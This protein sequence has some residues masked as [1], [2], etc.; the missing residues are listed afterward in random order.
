MKQNL[1]AQEASIPGLAETI[2]D[3]ASSLLVGVAQSGALDDTEEKRKGRL[4][5]Q[6]ARRAARIGSAE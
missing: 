4:D 2:V 5:R 6:A 3:P 1:A